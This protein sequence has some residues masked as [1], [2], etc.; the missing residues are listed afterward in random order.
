MRD[1]DNISIAD[2]LFDTRR[3]VGAPSVLVKRSQIAAEIRRL[4]TDPERSGT[5]ARI[6]NNAKVLS[7]DITR[8]SVSTDDGRTFSGDILIGADGINSVIRSA[9]LG[10]TSNLNSTLSGEQKLPEAEAQGRKGGSRP[11]GL[12]A[13]VTSV[14]REVIAS[15]ADLAFQADVEN[16][17]G[18]T[19][20]YGSAGRGAK[21]RVLLYPINKTHFQAVGYYPETSWVADFEASRSS[22]LKGRASSRIVEDFKGLHPSVR[23]LFRYAMS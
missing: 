16:S 20:Y 6:I 8:T 5:P 11:S 9:M 19:T 21:D 15:D 13:Y 22:I 23:K 14:P 1:K 4:A 7:V 3:T 10:S 18:L 12:V 17:A 2:V